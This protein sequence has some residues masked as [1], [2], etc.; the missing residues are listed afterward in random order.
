MDK[1]HF[2]HLILRLKSRI[3][4]ENTFEKCQRYWNSSHVN[5]EIITKEN[6]FFNEEFCLYLSNQRTL[7]QKI[8]AK[9]TYK[10]Y[11][12]LYNL[13]EWENILDNFEYC[14]DIDLEKISICQRT[15]CGTIETKQSPGLSEL[16]SYQEY[17]KLL[18]FPICDY[19]IAFGE[20]YGFMQ[21][22]TESEKTAFRKW[23]YYE[24]NE[25]ILLEDQYENKFGY[26]CYGNLILI[27]IQI[28]KHHQKFLK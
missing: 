17:Q 26:D 8:L 18:N 21:N 19:E 6:Y 20:Y 27:G 12:C 9:E 3:I 14:E 11:F 4:N 13:N 16:E 24:N 10:D 2:I 28:Y 23:F 7:N 22:S 15:N 1:N 5:E 25:I